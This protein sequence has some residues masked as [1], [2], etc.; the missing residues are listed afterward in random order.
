MLIHFSDAKEIILFKL[1]SI[2]ILK[3]HYYTNVKR[4]LN[5]AFLRTKSHIVVS[6]P[7][8][9]L[10][11]CSDSQKL[12]YFQPRGFHFGRIL[13]LRNDWPSPWE[14]ISLLKTKWNKHTEKQIKYPKQQP[15][16][17]FLCLNL[18]H[19]EIE[20]HKHRLRGA[21]AFI[22]NLDEH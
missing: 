1:N 13:I 9:Y 22:K 11:M 7:I 2:E 5:K 14:E 16:T 4:F 17:L 8:L 10:C 3:K 20:V 21:E 19:M 6:T 18:V 15:P 12:H